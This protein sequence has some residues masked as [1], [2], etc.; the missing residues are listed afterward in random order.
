MLLGVI[1]TD[2][3]PD[4]N[5]A[6]LHTTYSNKES[7]FKAQGILTHPIIL[8]LGTPIKKGADNFNINCFCLSQSF[9]F[10]KD[11]MGITSF[12]RLKAT[13]SLGDSDI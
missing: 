5:L 6:I 2:L 4:K 11:L 10:C 12:E 9:L 7:G 3:Q 1:V 8:S 13:I